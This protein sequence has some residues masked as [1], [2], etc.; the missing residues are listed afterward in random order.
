LNTKRIILISSLLALAFAGIW[1]LRG[2]RAP[3]VPQESNAVA[4]GLPTVSGGQEP[5]V[6]EALVSE[7]QRLLAAGPLCGLKNLDTAKIKAFKSEAGF[8]MLRNGDSEAIFK[9]G[10]LVKAFHHRLGYFS[11]QRGREAFLDWNDEAMVSWNKSQAVSATRAVL[12]RLGLDPDISR[13]EYEGG[14]LPLKARSGDLKRVALFSIV[15]LYDKNG[16]MIVDAEWR[17]DQTGGPSLTSWFQN[18]R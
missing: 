11:L 10:K 6:P 2:K 7:W 5:K 17:M 4:G 18:I 13:D 12:T 15:R 3:S 16:N 14:A 9:D 1:A 8:T